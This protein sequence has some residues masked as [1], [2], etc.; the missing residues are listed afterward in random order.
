MYVKFLP[1]QYVL[2]YR[3]GRLAAEGAGLSFFYLERNTSACAMPVSN[4]YSD[5]IYEENTADFQ[6][7]TVQGQLTYRI[8]DFRKAAAA[9]DFTVNLRSRT[10][11]YYNAPMQKLAKR[12]INISEVLV[13]N[14]IGELA[15]TDVLS[16][17]SEFA[18]E[19]LAEFAENTELAALGVTV[20]GFS[21]LNIAANPETARALEAATREDILKQSD[22]ALYERRNAAIEQERRV[23]ENELNTEISVQ[24]KKKTIK[25][26][27]IQ[28]ERMVLE[29][30]AEM[31]C[32]RIEKEAERKKIQLEAEIELEKKRKELAELRLENEKKQADAEGYR[33]AAVMKAYANIQPDVLVALAALDMEPERLIAQAFEKLAA[34]SEKIGTL[35]ITPDLLDSLAGKG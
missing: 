13:R 30:K 8:T 25:E 11:E 3:K 12:I 19:V 32:I 2:R 20:S 6:K 5:F 26:T 7:I 18:A 24:E 14:R 27:E 33:I 9:V 35:N 34:N 1:S 22:D 4:N 23:K 28:T 21:I 16:A 10:K 31:E 17:G 29:R 15:L